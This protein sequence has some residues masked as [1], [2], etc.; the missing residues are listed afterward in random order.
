MPE[1][2]TQTVSVRKNSDGSVSGC[3]TNGSG[4]GFSLS[5]DCYGNFYLFTLRSSG[6]EDAE[7]RTEFW[8]MDLR[9]SEEDGLY[10]P[11]TASL[12]LLAECVGRSYMYYA[13]DGGALLVESGPDSSLLTRVTPAGEL[14][15]AYAIPRPEGTY[16]IHIETGEGWVLADTLDGVYAFD[17]SG[18]GLVEGPFFDIG[19]APGYELLSRPAG[20]Y[21]YTL[22]DIYEYDGERLALF[23]DFAPADED[24]PP[25]DYIRWQVQNS[26][27]FLVCADALGNVCVQQL[28]SSLQTEP[29][30]QI[31]YTLEM[32]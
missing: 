13:P 27:A 23:L 1:D 16:S 30:E 20:E 5:C 10:V 6:S 2:A 19:G 26:D 21:R 28:P 18:G 12:R 8:L 15:E 22:E 17:Y 14:A 3:G 11:D 29:A 9:W 7:D 24:E 31:S 32:R 4:A 25:Q